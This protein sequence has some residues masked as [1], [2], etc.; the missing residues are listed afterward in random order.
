[1]TLKRAFLS[2]MIGIVIALGFLTYTMTSAPSPHFI[3]SGIVESA[4]GPMKDQPRVVAQRKPG[5]HFVVVVKFEENVTSTSAKTFI[6]SIEAANKAGADEVVVMLNTVGGDVDSGIKMAK[7]VEDSEAPVTC[8]VDTEAESMGF[9]ILQ[10]CPVRLMTKRSELMVHEPAIE[11]DKFHGKASDYRKVQE[12]L[13]SLN[14]AMTEHEGHRLTVDVKELRRRIA[15]REWYMNWDEAV[16]MHAVDGVADS[17]RNVVDSLKKK[18][19]SPGV[20]L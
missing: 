7:A 19:V 14:R 6:A 1:M 10:S 4:A 3:A 16:K 17:V 11:V 12:R 13:D 2:V 9:Y 5:E 20:G 15:G 8:V 18:S